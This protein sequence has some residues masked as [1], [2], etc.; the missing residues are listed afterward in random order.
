MVVSDYIVLYVTKLIIPISRLALVCY[1]RV[2]DSARKRMSAEL[3]LQHHWLCQD[4]TYMRAK[5]LSTATHL[6]FL[7]R[8]KWQ[9]Y[10]A[11]TYA[12]I[13]GKVPIKLN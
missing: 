3:C 12:F 4:V 11:Y 9:V 7:L 1:N 5:R 13:S 6:K 10:H 8:R 2:F